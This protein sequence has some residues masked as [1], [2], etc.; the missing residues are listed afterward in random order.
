MIYS[1]SILILFFQYQTNLLIPAIKPILHF[2]SL[3]FFSYVILDQSF[4]TKP[5]MNIGTVKV[6]NQLGKISYGL[7]LLH[8]VIIYPL[9]KFEISNPWLYACIYI[10]VILATI[11]LSKVTFQ[12]IESPFLKMKKK[13]SVI[14]KE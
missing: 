6:L 4:S 8:M 9:S 14:Q 3:V 12:L 2:L 5:W 13:L 1:M 11:V 7:Y 10:L